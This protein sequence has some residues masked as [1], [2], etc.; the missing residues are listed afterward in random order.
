MAK[1]R[2]MV[3]NLEALAG[4]LRK[5]YVL[6]AERGDPSK[7]VIE[8]GGSSSGFGLYEPKFTYSNGVLEVETPDHLGAISKEMSFWASVQQ[9][10]ENTGGRK[11]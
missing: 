8:S 1:Q 11:A 3:K 10:V 5:P 4:E 6:R 7:G 2:Y 9:A